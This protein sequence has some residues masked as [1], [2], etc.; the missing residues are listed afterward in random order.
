MLEPS[1]PDTEEMVLSK[2][3]WRGRC[4]VT[5]PQIGMENLCQNRCQQVRECGEM[6]SVLQ[7]AER[8]V[9]EARDASA[10]NPP[11]AHAMKTSKTMLERRLAEGQDVA[12][13]LEMKAAENPLLE[14][15]VSE[16]TTAMDNLAAHIKV[17]RTAVAKVDASADGA[18]PGPLVA[19]VEAVE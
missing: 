7:A 9:G 11:R 5:F 17:M 13:V 19:H 10:R 15:K 6:D 2:T 3:T 8:I 16:M 4:K 12:T 1:Q 18:G 14:S